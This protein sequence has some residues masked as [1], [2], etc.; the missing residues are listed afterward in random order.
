MYIYTN[1]NKTRKNKHHFVCIIG[2]VNQNKNDD[3]ENDNKY[4]IQFPSQIVN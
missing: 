1:E 3:D 2:V 4:F